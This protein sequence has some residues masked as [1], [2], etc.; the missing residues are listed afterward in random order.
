MTMNRGF[1]TVQFTNKAATA[2]MVDFDFFEIDPAA[3]KPVEI[4]AIFIGQET[5]EGDT[6]EDFVRWAL[7]RFTGGTFTSGG[8]LATTPVKLDS[9]DGAASFAA[10][11]FNAVGTVATTTGTTERVHSDTFNVRTGLQVVFPPEMR[12][13]C[14]GAANEAMVVRCE[15][16]LDA[17]TN[18]S[19]TLYVVET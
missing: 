14:S 7:L 17:T 2:A 3:D 1:Y 16:T 9:N 19:G 5:A 6:N 15:S 18:F 10:E 4:V 8:E 11:A 12:P 13:K